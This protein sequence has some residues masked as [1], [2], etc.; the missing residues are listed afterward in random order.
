VL[1][2]V[3]FEAILLLG[4]LAS[5]VNKSMMQF[6]FEFNFGKPKPQDDD[7]HVHEHWDGFKVSMYSW[8]KN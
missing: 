7:A 8:V 1:L 6:V 2:G 5:Y 3:P 4:K